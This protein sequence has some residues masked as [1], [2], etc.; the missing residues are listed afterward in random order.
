MFPPV[1]KPR[2]SGMTG[3]GDTGRQR[4][5]PAFSG[6]RI[7]IIYL[8]APH[9]PLLAILGLSLVP[10][11]GSSQPPRNSGL[12]PHP[13]YL[14][15]SV[16]APVSGQPHSLGPL[17]TLTSMLSPMLASPLQPQVPLLNFWEG[18]PLQP[19]RIPSPSWAPSE[20]CHCLLC[21]VCAMSSCSSLCSTPWTLIF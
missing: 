2:A 9:Y 6:D 3:V 5:K 8:L 20:T 7:K 19:L 14:E 18:V 13:V 12:A 21:L 11:V 17:L 16:S 10:L 15:P 4:R 1:Q